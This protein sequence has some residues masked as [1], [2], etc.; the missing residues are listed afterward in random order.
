MPPITC[1]PVAAV[2][3][4]VCW[5]APVGPVSRSIDTA[6]ACR[7]CPR[8]RASHSRAGP[9]PSGSGW[10]PGR[11]PRTAPCARRRRSWCRK[12]RPPTAVA[13]PAAGR[14]RSRRPSWRAPRP[15]RSPRPAADRI[16]EPRLPDRDHL[17]HPHERVRHAVGLARDEAGR[18]GTCRV[19]RDP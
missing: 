3:V 8:A 19:R 4:I 10:R 6:P 1:R 14:P 7:C 5:G 11:S 18:A 9:C 13:G 16:T 12:A 2:K 15:R 17:P